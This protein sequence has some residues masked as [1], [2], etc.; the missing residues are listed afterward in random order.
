VGR[1]SDRHDPTERD[2]V[3]VGFGAHHVVVKSS[4]PGVGAELFRTFGPMACDAP[5]G[6]EAG[7]LEAVLDAAGVRIIG[8]PDGTDPL[9]VAPD[10]APRE[11]YHAT[12]KLLMRARPDLVWVHAGVAAYGNRA[13]LFAGPSGQGKST[14]VGALLDRGWT[15]LSDEFAAIGAAGIVHPFPLAPRR[16]VHDGSFVLLDEADALRGLRKV[17]VEFPPGAVGRRPVPLERIYFLRYSPS[18]AAVEQTRSTPAQAVLE[19]LRNSLN[20][21]S[22]REREI[23]LLAQIAGGVPSLLHIG[24]PSVEAAAAAVHAAAAS[25][26]ASA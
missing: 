19:L 4:V 20:M 2:V 7:C 23:A 13:Y 5:T 3:W 14:L 15:Y 1:S 8:S 9:T 6:L 17:D 25:R 11:L 12:V 22:D 10:W 16:R 18:I 24:Y 26:S 21:T